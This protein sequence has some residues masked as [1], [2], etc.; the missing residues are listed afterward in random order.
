[1]HFLPHV[2]PML[3]LGLVIPFGIAAVYWSVCNTL[4]T[5]IGKRVAGIH[6]VNAH[7][8][9]PGI[10]RGLLRTFVALVLSGPLLDL[11]YLWAFWQR[12]RRSW[13]DIIAGTYV[14][15]ILPSD[16]KDARQSRPAEMVQPPAP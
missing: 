5:S 4:G 11:G 14:V 13:H 3:L 6:I 15:R 16:R 8:G 10:A 7:G 1:M 12:R 9:R 2:A